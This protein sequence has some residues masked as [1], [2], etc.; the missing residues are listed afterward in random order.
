[1]LYFFLYGIAAS[2]QRQKQ[3]LGVYVEHEA[4]HMAG[5]EEAHVE[6]EARVEQAAHV[7]QEA[8]K[9]E[10]GLLFEDDG[11]E[12]GAPHGGVQ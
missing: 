7:E 10:D 5:E 6:D 11:E 4:Q 9:E 12:E 2:R 8:P 3:I 1:M